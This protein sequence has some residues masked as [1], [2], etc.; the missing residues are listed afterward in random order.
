MDEVNSA[1]KNFKTEDEGSEVMR[2][3]L[4]LK[5]AMATA[6][7]ALQ[8]NRLEAA[9][10]DEMTRNAA[11]LCLQG[12]ELPVEMKV[13]ITKRV[14]TVH[15]N[16]QKLDDWLGCLSISSTTAWTA[17]SPSFGGSVKHERCAIPADLVIVEAFVGAAL[18]D[19]LMRL[20]TP[21]DEPSEMQRRC[22]LLLKACKAYLLQH[23]QE[24]HSAADNS[25]LKI[26]SG[27]VAK[28][29]RGVV[30]LLSPIPG[31]CGS[32]LEH[33]EYVNPRNAT[34]APLLSDIPKLGRLILNKLR[35]EDAWT[36]V[37]GPGPNSTK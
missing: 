14:A 26:V 5:K 37:T 34:S 28:V 35:R 4:E 21:A 9:D 15:L 13:N 2:E 17:Q 1:L 23:D 7:T 10:I 3:E 36:L 25:V 8:A 19:A 30:A 33:V 31:D 27:N 22:D 16:A 20:L 18:P 32:G 29:F 24:G 12:I 11:L 6:A